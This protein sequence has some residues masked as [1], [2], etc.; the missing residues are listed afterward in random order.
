MP[1]SAPSGSERC[2][3]DRHRLG[4]DRALL[5]H[6]HRDHEAP[7]GLH[8]QGLHGG[9]DSPV[10]RAAPRRTPALQDVRHRRGPGAE[11]GLIPRR[12]ADLPSWWLPDPLRHPASAGLSAVQPRRP[13]RR[14]TGPRVQHGGELHHQHQLA[15]LRRR[16][17]AVV[18]DP[19]AGL[20]AP[21]LPLGRDR[22]RA[23]CRDDPGL[24]RAPPPRP[25]AHSG[26]TSPGAPSTSCCRSALST[27][28]SWSGRASRRR[29]D[30]M[31][32][33]RRWKVPSRRSRWGRS[34][35]RSR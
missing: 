18:P 32:M 34:P 8:D 30:R 26:S 24:F 10:P 35:A 9:E 33:R 12:D 23:R 28:C 2:R 22:H 15:E 20:D 31:S 14:R 25:S 3:H 16:D 7:R 19:N 11:L 6:H 13:G 1:S 17:H 5:R 4:S 29:S 27:R 21:E